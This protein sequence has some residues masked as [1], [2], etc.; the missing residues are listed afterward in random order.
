MPDFIQHLQCFF[1]SGIVDCLYLLSVHLQTSYVKGTVGT[2]EQGIA[3][4]G[5]T[6]NVIELCI[7]HL[8]TYVHHACY[9]RIAVAPETQEPVYQAGTGLAVGGWLCKDDYAALVALLLQELEGDAV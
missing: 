6:G 5:L 7:V 3:F 9:L 2:D 8:V 4:S 1:A